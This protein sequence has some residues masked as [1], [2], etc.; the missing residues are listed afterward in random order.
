[1]FI[2]GENHVVEDLTTMVNTDLLDALAS[3]L[4][5]AHR[6]RA[7]PIDMFF[8]ESGLAR[9]PDLQWIDDVVRLSIGG[10][11]ANDELFIL[12][13][14][15][16]LYQN[17]RGKITELTAW[18]SGLIDLF[19][20]FESRVFESMNSASVRKNLGYVYD[21]TQRLFEVLDYT[22]KPITRIRTYLDEI[23]FRLKVIE[24]AL[25][26]LKGEMVRI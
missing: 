4:N 3:E 11:G 15:P 26:L 21:T 13:S 6:D 1:M 10:G 20:N 5:G 22:D 18:S 23:I 8:L 2:I 14:Y 16:N 7:I 12:N 25:C 17:I 24:V 9:P 19:K